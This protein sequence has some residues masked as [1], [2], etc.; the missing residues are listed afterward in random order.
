[1]ILRKCSQGCWVPVVIANTE[2]GEVFFFGS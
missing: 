1:M 2:K